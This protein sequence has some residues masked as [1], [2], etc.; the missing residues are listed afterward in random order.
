MDIVNIN[1]LTR[2]KY[3][4]PYPEQAVPPE[5][6]EE[7]DQEEEPLEFKVNLDLLNNALKNANRL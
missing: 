4:E 2:P 6:S 1:S 5:P 7:T 3:A